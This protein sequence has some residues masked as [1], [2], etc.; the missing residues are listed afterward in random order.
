MPA[1]KDYANVVILPP[2]ALALCVGAAFFA[3]RLWPAPFLPSG[4]PRWPIGGALI[5]LGLM[6][7]FWALVLFRR[8]RTSILPIRP[9]SAIIEAG[10]YRYSR[11]PIYVGMFV[12]V[13][14]AAIGLDSLWQFAASSRSMSCSGGAWWRAKRPISRENSARPIGITPSGSGGGCKARSQ[15]AG[16]S[17]SSSSRFCRAAELF[18]STP[19]LRSR[20]SACQAALG[21]T[22]SELSASRA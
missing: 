16:F 19:R 8:A 15:G 9:T 12:I 10:P 1:H 6:T 3:D 17:R 5:A 7:E 21:N 4:W 11:N 14:G 20:E 13:V 22:F 2:V 18:R